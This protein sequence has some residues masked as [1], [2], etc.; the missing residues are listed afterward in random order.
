[1]YGGLQDQSWEEARHLRAGVRRETQG[2]GARLQG[3]LRELRGGLPHGLTS[4]SS[5]SSSWA[6]TGSEPALAVSA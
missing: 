2:G 3:S 6:R 4:P 5:Q 1:M